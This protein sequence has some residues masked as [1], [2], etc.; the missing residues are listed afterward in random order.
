MI[1][2]E[3]QNLRK[4]FKDVTAVDG[5]SLSVEKGEVHGILGPNGAG[6]STAINCLL[7]L[8]SYDSGI[9]SFENGIPIKKW[10][11]NIGY[12]PQDLAIYP[13]LTAAENIRFFCSLYGIKGNELGPVF[14]IVV[15]L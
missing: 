14:R 11:R 10:S 4:M 13:D 3:I 15:P 12:V 7:G 9:V 6:K 5:L 8:I 1:L 2:L